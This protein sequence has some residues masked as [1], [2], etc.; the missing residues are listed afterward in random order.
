MSLVNHLI[1]SLLTEC[2]SDRTWKSRLKQWNARKCDQIDASS[3]AADLPSAAT[4]PSAFTPSASFN[5]PIST[6][7]SHYDNSTRLGPLAPLQSTESLPNGNFEPLA[8]D[9]HI[10]RGDSPLLGEFFPQPTLPD[11]I[12]MLDSNAH[13]E[14]PDEQDFQ[15]PIQQT[16]STGQAQDSESTY[17]PAE[18]QAPTWMTSAAQGP[19]NSLP[20]GVALRDRTNLRRNLSQKAYPLDRPDSF[21]S[22][23]SGYHTASNRG[24]VMTLASSGSSLFRAGSVSRPG[25]E[26][27]DNAY[28]V[29]SN[30]GHSSLQHE[31]HTN[32]PYSNSRLATHDNGG[33]ITEELSFEDTNYVYFPPHAAPSRC[34]FARHQPYNKTLAV[35]DGCPHCGAN[36]FH[37]LASVAIT[38]N[39][40]ELKIQLKA[41]KHHKPN[42]NDCD[43]FGNSP[44]HF[45]ASC[46]PRLDHIQAF[47]QAGANL[48]IRNHHNE[49]F[50]HVLNI[51]ALG[52]DLHS[53]LQLYA[54]NVD[55]P[56]RTLF[57]RRRSHDSKSIL[58]CLA[59]Q[60]PDSNT[61]P[62]I[63]DWFQSMEVNIQARDNQGLTPLDYLF[64]NPTPP[65]VMNQRPISDR[66]QNVHELQI[67]NQEMERVIHNCLSDPF[68]EDA[69]G[70]NALICLAYTVMPPRMR[71][72]LLD[73]CIARGV[74]L[75]HFDKQ[76]KTPIH[77]F[78]LKPR[79]SGGYREDDEL[80]AAFV[81]KLIHAG[82]N[83]N[84]R[85]HHGETPL[86][87]AA[88]WGHD[89]CTRLLLH[90][91][92]D[93]NA[94]NVR[95]RSVIQEATG[96]LDQNDPDLYGRI[97]LC[98][99]LVGA[100]GGRDD[101]PDD[102]AM[103]HMRQQSM[104]F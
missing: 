75:D 73:S 92:A 42:I 103:Q 59:A 93:P 70:H 82:A 99:A 69:E 43:M 61:T 94:V 71:F 53:V 38:L 12:E 100:R 47:R 28:P 48:H 84:L 37:Y 96:W 89:F 17:S 102:A 97:K 52:Q 44:L 19:K 13:D 57:L 21:R 15:L 46:R 101:P 66:S 33:P 39:F 85:D 29:N 60:K 16:L 67:K 54:R 63:V 87:F 56:R 104:R 27:H 91:G 78:I 80:T 58:H 68:L 98:I 51:H 22:N 50:L 34:I 62:V 95:G 24:S 45:L 65:P 83:I 81:A 20:I 1:A 3:T 41:L 74:D 49:T 2:L 40:E 88:K 86:H 77:A 8:E 36:R 32:K 72:D 14:V 76:G 11:D 31:F 23:D 30:A 7:T 90:H 10:P 5:F 9:Q 18:A 79:F 64:S 4:T 6:P 55:S 25:I 35:Q 26:A